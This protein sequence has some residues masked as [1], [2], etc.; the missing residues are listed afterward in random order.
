M[1]LSKFYFQFSFKSG[2]GH[3]HLK[4][5]HWHHL[6]SLELYDGS[7]VVVVVTSDKADRS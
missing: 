3:F 1:I 4:M 5:G 2:L 6:I 7:G